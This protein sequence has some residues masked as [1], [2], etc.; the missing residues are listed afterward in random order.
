MPSVVRIFA[1][2]ALVVA[3]G[4]GLW[5]V[6]GL[7]VHEGWIARNPLSAYADGAARPQPPAARPAVEAPGPVQW[8]AQSGAFDYQ[9]HALRSEKLWT[10]DGA[11]DGFVMATGDFG[12]ADGAGLMVTGV[13]PGGILRSPS[14]LNVDGRNRSYVLVRLTRLRNGGRWDG[15][16]YYSTAA[17]GE[18]VAYHAKP[19]FGGDPAIN[20]TVVLVYDMSQLQA[21]GA[22]WLQSRIQQV[23]I[24]LDGDPGGAFI[25]RQFAIAQSPQGALAEAQPK[26][27]P[28]QNTLTDPLESTAP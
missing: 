10:F 17:H 21:G 15:S 5:A 1:T 28:R 25:I 22:D 14:G 3:L 19:I 12:P 18:A 20:Q 13:K 6:G 2:L 11:T 9:G 7:A 27:P 4:L 24:D 23:R 26:A 8:N 16:L